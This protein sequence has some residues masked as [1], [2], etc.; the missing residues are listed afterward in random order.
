MAYFMVFIKP[1]LMGKRTRKSK[2]VVFTVNHDRKSLNFTFASP[3][4]T[5]RYIGA[6]SVPGTLDMFFPLRVEK[7][8]HAVGV[9]FRSDGVR[10]MNYMRLLKLLYIADREALKE[11]GRPITGGRLVAMERGPVPGEI[12]DLIRGQHT[13]MPLWDRFFRTERYDLE[14]VEDPDVRKLSRYE[15]TKLQEVATRHAQDDEWELS[16][17]THTFEEWNKN[18]PAAGTSRD[19]GLNDI[20]AALGLADSAAEIAEDARHLVS[21]EHELGGHG[22]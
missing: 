17:L 9:L 22:R 18:K 3:G 7:T 20:L 15:I 10:R 6:T 16:R 2:T 13:H 14:M 12:H 5:I 19:I 8:I 1:E 11:T 21:I 4:F